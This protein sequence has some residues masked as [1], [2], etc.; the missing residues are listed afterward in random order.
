MRELIDCTRQHRS[1][2]PNRD[3]PEYKVWHSKVHTI[4][5]LKNILDLEDTAVRALMVADP[6]VVKAMARENGIFQPVVAGCKWTGKAKS[7]D[8]INLF[9]KTGIHNFLFN[10]EVSYEW[11][12]WYK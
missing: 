1:T 6:C 8:A 12:Q 5:V 7:V 11:M 4:M 10:K 3:N 9:K 2:L